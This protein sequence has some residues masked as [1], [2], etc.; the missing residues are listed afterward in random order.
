MFLTGA[1]TAIPRRQATIRM[2]FI[3][4]KACKEIFWV[5]RLDNIQCITQNSIWIDHYL[6]NS[7]TLWYDTSCLPFPSGSTQALADCRGGVWVLERDLLL[8]ISWQNKGPADV[9]QVLVMC[10]GFLFLWF[11]NWQLHPRENSRYTFLAW[12][13]H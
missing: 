13:A 9:W 3:L 10:Q 11:Q 12:N 1:Q 5:I 6:N 7:S 4:N 2:D 8:F